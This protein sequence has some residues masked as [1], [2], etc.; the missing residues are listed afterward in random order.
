MKTKAAS[1]SLMK[2]EEG[3][4]FSSNLEKPTTTLHLMYSNTALERGEEEKTLM[5]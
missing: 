2:T 5:G 3:N 1:S 4:A